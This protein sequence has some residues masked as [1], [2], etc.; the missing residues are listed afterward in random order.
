VRQALPT[1]AALLIAG[2][3][4]GATAPAADTLHAPSASAGC[5][6]G[7]ARYDVAV[8]GHP[9]S[10]VQSRDGSAL[11]VSVIGNSPA[12]GNG[13]A[14]L[15]CRDGRF[16]YSHLSPL[17]SSP[18]GM[19]GTHDGKL[20]IVADD[21]FVAF[22]DVRRALLGRPA[23]LGY[24]QDAEGDPEDNDAG[25]VD[26]NV[27]PD[28]RYAFVA[29]ED[30]RAITVIDLARAR[31]GGFT[32]AAIVGRIPV[33]DAPIALV[34]SADGKYLFTTSEVALESYKYAPK[35]RP[36]GAGPKAALTVAPGVIQ[37]IDV[38]VAE[39]DPVHAL[40]GRFAGACSPV[41]MAIAPDGKTVFVTNRNSN[42]VTAYSTARLIAGGPDALTAT[43]PVGAGPVA[44]AVTG[45][46]RYVL[47]GNT[48]R[49]GPS[50]PSQGTISVID[51]TS[52]RVSG[53]IPVGIFPR[54]LSPGI[55]SILFLSNNR[56]NR[57]TVFDTSRLSEVVSH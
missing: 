8:P 6:S 32:R 7:A 36:E 57:I 15:R 26:V 34:F 11:F 52:M 13:I 17:E 35:C 54:Q 30:N 40:I 16:R 53:T 41:R 48:N 51:T 10:A 14:V 18:L 37:T 9:F 22:V 1:I 55:G 21:G 50:G 29:D 24:F 47:A 2:I 45:D 20:L 31:A 38:H 28:D 23:L 56:S 5:V 33:A 4:G 3:G 43:I 44:L 49:F 42:S 27:T 19:V 12:R 25:S 39:T 46:G